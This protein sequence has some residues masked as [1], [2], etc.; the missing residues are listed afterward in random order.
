MNP[1][2]LS[3]S[4]FAPERDCVVASS[5]STPGQTL[6]FSALHALR[7][8]FDT[9]ALRLAAILLSLWLG[10]AMAFAA[11]LIYEPF[12]Y[13][14]GED[15]YGQTN[16]S[17]GFVWIKGSHTQ[18]DSNTVVEASSLSL[19]GLR[20]SSGNCIRLYDYG[21][22][23]T[24]PFGSTV[25]NGTVFYSALIKV[26]DPSTFQFGLSIV[27]ALASET[28]FPGSTGGY[29]SAGLVV[30]GSNGTYQ[31]GT[32][33]TNWTSSDF[34]YD[35]QLFT[36]NDT[37]LVVAAYTFHGGSESN[38]VVRLWVQPS[39]ATFGAPLAPAASV[40]ITN[41]LD[42][43]DFESFA[44]LRNY[45]SVL[46]RMDEVRVGTTWADV[47]PIPVEREHL[48]FGDAPTNYP[49][50]FFD[51]GARHKVVG[52]LF[53]GMNV[54]EE[55]EGQPSVNADGDDIAGPTDDEN[56]VTFLNPI[57]P[58]GTANLN[59]VVTG[60]GKLDA[61]LDFNQNGNWDPA[62]KIINSIPVVNGNNALSFPV[63]AGAPL[64]N[65]YARFRLSSAGGLTPMGLADNGEVEDYLV[66]I[67]PPP[68]QLFDYG[69]APTN[70]P[71][72]LSQNGARHTVFSTVIGPMHLGLNID[73][74]PDA[75]P[76][77]AATGDD[78]N[79]GPD[80]EDGV[81][82]TTP[83]TA[84]VPAT[85]TITASHNGR[86]DA[87]LDFDRNGVW[88][89]VDQI[90][91]SQAVVAGANLLSFPV[92]AGAVSGTTFA[93][94][95]YS[96][97]G[98][99]TPVGAAVDGEVEDYALEIQ[100]APPQ[101]F[102]YGDAPTNYPTLLAN[103]GA[104]H[105]VI[106]QLFLGLNVDQEPD[107]QP[108]PAADGD[109][110]NGGPDD[111]NGVTFLN[112]LVPGGVANVNVFVTG[113]G[114]LDA[115]IDWDH[116]GA[117]DPAE[118]I[119]TSR[120]V[121]NGNNA[122]SFAVPA[123]AAPGSTYAR[124]RL[125]TA[126]GLLPA[127]LANDGEV[128]DYRVEIN[129]G[130]L[131]VPVIVIS[132][133]VGPSNVLEQLSAAS[134]TLNYTN[135]G[136]G[137]ASNCFI[138][139][140]IPA[141][142]APTA[143][144]T[145]PLHPY[146][147]AGSIYTFNLGDLNP[148]NF[149]TIQF[150]GIAAN[151]GV[152]TNTA[153]MT[154]S[155]APASSS[156]VGFT[157]VQPNDPD[158]PTNPPPHNLAPCICGPVTG[159]YVS[160]QVQRWFVQCDGGML[161]FRVTARTV[162][163]ND[164]QVTIADIYDGGALLGTVTVS[165]TAAEAAAHGLGWETNQSIALGPFPPGKKLRVEVR[166]GGT[167][168]TQTHYWLKFCG[169]RWLAITSESFE[170]LEDDNAAYRFIVKPAEA[171]VVDI[172][173][174]GI[175]APAGMMDY[176]LIDPSGT[177]YS[178]GSFPI[179]PADEFTI[180]APMPGL[181]T[182][183]LQP[184]PGSGEH[185][186]LNKRSGADRH[187]YM[188]W[189][190]SQRGRKVVEITL[191]GVPAVGTPFE[192]QMLRRRE[193]SAG[194][195]N[196]LMATTVV[197]NGH[198]EFDKLA[199]GYYDVSV[200]PLVPGITNLP[201]QLDLILCDT[202]V[203]NRFDFH[204]PDGQQ[205][206]DFGDA[207]APYPTLL[208]DDGAR[209]LRSHVT[210]QYN[211]SWDASTNLDFEPDGQ[212]NATASGDDSNGRNDE[213]SLVIFH[214][215]NETWLDGMSSA[216]G[217]VDAW[218][219]FDNNGVWDPS[220]KVFNS[221]S[222]PTGVWALQIQVPTN[223]PGGNYFSRF[224]ISSAG[225]LNP[226]GLAPDG[227]VQDKLVLVL[228][229]DDT[230][231]NNNGTPG[232]TE[233]G[234]NFTFHVSVTNQPGLGTA[235]GVIANLTLANFAV[236]Q[237]TS[238]Q[239]T[240]Q[241]SSNGVTVSIGELPPGAGTDVTVTGHYLPFQSAGDVTSVTVTN[242]VTVSSDNRDLNPGNNAL[243]LPVIVL[244]RLDYGDAP[245]PTYPTLRAINGARHDASNLH[246][247]ALWDAERNG[248]PNATATGDNLT[249]ANDEDGVGF[250]LLTPGAMA[251]ANI[252]SSGAGLIN[253]WI[254]WDHNGVW[255]A[256]EQILIN[257][258]VVAGPNALNFP[259]PP[260][261]AAGT[262]FARIRLSTVPGLA[263]TGYA[264]DGEVEDYRVTIAPP[265]PAMGNLKLTG[266]QAGMNFTSQPGV[267]YRLQFKNSLFETNWTDGPVVIGDGSTQSLQDTNAPSR[268]RFYRLKME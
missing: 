114:L 222:V 215:G 249:A 32:F 68:Q 197:T 221:A 37:V 118:Q 218:V 66:A 26:D 89:P 169:A 247:G 117:W 145:T 254:D 78:V 147:V 267:R 206:M 48:D 105:R 70:Y 173:T 20:A 124:F 45:G 186:L 5:R 152:W 143:V 27:G 208:A 158:F 24:L 47:T 199:N 140:T 41:G 163:T 77:P 182:L 109:D 126:G 71:T 58:G 127:G 110:L 131:Q 259:V 205:E 141:G 181:W 108:S 216:P 75:F 122:V 34:E 67:Q 139:D 224:R 121:V 88:D 74:E 43:P 172:N 230:A 144:N 159:N 207:P 155:N 148:G 63:P 81:V 261:I 12:D 262:T 226:T 69:D 250:T 85:V 258:P 229:L 211:P 76:N 188:D 90:F 233:E 103:N 195:T 125:S 33:K 194:I 28:N 22:E 170:S 39:V 180:A 228:D 241:A 210:F 91:T 102:D 42:Q 49:T 86:I 1:I 107:G 18:D 72:L 31:V 10:S 239:G 2:P 161:D 92:P 55:A 243:L 29:V 248:L 138:T 65:T 177:I 234:D 225:G 35:S 160:N 156:S 53:L 8:V 204:G 104:R 119:F 219:D 19:P 30:A 246:L 189:H 61:W 268:S 7:L 50:L 244:R 154:S 212:P 260:G 95:R 257:A 9:A 264:L 191:N 128:E 213:N 183:Q 25:T 6:A 14:A 153:T 217:K 252:V 56:G 200:T 99:L 166:V 16:S 231:A 113:V 196:D 179:S 164:P 192:V 168:E 242:K 13:M 54:D 137:V 201:P 106:G 187:I 135:L 38:D 40:T 150:W 245:D 227:E 21:R 97:A 263:P 46:M 79:G 130:Q 94:F 220:E 4:H 251:T 214:L 23:A 93:R 112:P 64:G 136:P 133:Q 36:S 83:I 265:P 17:S 111:E 171:L 198:V 51:N 120:A 238:G 132:K 101:L 80:D 162:N 96:T 59:V 236:T 185:Y 62:D 253:A 87:W 190:T 82:F 123:G 235:H 266:G 255:D 165:Y 129:P 3:R 146:V 149:G 167:P 57:S 209:H 44:V 223:T 232:N 193:T 142:F 100:Q 151:L 175:V 176:R 240:G 203:T 115:W 178:A 98:G 73:D 84:G 157:V 60:S 237:V 116:N 202:P 11:G 174:N 184:S 52:Q 256:P 134:F 15:L